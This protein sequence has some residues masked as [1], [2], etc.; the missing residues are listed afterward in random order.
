VINASTN[1]LAQY[2]ATATQ[3]R[4]FGDGAHGERAMFRILMLL[5]ILVLS[6]CNGGEP[7]AQQGSVANEPGTNAAAAGAGG[8]PD[9]E[10]VA[11]LNR[12]RE[13]RYDE[14]VTVC[15]QALRNNPGDPQILKAIELSQDALKENGDS[16]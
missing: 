1:E 15:G 8:A 6:A 3:I 11:C 13:K 5:M 7:T 4:L 14:A 12:F 9:E 10:L 2:N 16:E